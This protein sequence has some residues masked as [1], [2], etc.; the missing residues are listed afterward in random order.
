[1]PYNDGWSQEDIDIA[2]AKLTAS[3]KKW[4][5]ENAIKAMKKK[6]GYFALGEDGKQTWVEKK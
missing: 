4:H 3:E 2:I 5:S 6:G 1:M